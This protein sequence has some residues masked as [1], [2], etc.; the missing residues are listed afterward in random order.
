MLFLLRELI[1]IKELDTASA[2][3]NQQDYS[4]DKLSF[5]L[6]TKTRKKVT[7]FLFLFYME[8]IILCWLKVLS[9]IHQTS[10]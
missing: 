1:L 3:E 2:V 8:G 9:A 10:E 6:W 4:F 5:Q 7:F